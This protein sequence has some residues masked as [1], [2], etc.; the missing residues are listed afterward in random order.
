[1]HGH[2]HWTTERMKFRNIRV[3]GGA[4]EKLVRGFIF[5]LPREQVEHM[6]GMLDDAQSPG[7]LAGRIS[8]C[9]LFR[10]QGR[11]H[12]PPYWQLGHLG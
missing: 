1:M 9:C 3:H 10:R 7:A 8:L 11:L 6:V 12:P 5:A 4:R 2:V